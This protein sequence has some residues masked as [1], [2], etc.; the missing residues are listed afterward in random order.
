MIS[1]NSLRLNESIFFSNLISSR[2]RSRFSACSRLKMACSCLINFF[3]SCERSLASLISCLSSFCFASYLRRS[4]SLI[5]LSFSFF[6]NAIFLSLSIFLFSLKS[7]Y[8]VKIG[9]NK[10][11]IIFLRLNFFNWFFCFSNCGIFIFLNFVIDIFGLIFFFDFLIFFLLLI[12][13]TIF[14]LLLNLIFFLFFSFLTLFL[15]L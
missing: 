1:C 14:I 6:S 13:R 10:K 9:C 15:I 3:R 11:L 5:C 4:S 7:S 12:F 2:K 8:T